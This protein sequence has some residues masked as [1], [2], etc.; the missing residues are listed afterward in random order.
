MHEK[1]V[2]IGYLLDFYGGLLNENRRGAL[3]MYYNSDM[4]L[5]EISAEMGITRQGV[6][7]LIGKGGNELLL[8]EEK[9][10]MARKFREIEAIVE[11]LRKAAASAGESGGVIEEAADSIIG[12]ISD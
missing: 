5:S 9:L 8:Y 10:G 4:S 6:R 3:D 2:E 7:D 1:N 11:T 12:I